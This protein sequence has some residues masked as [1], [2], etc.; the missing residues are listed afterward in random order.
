MKSN[1]LIKREVL[2]L[3]LTTDTILTIEGI[4]EDKLNCC[5][6]NELTAE[7]EDFILEAGLEQWRERR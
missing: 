3:S 4:K 2:P 7:Q 1:F 6:N 5:L